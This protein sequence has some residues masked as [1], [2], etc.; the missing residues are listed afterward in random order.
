MMRLRGTFG[1][2]AVAVAVLGACSGTDETVDESGSHVTRDFESSDDGPV[3][4]DSESNPFGGND[5]EDQLMP[6]V[7]C[8][9]LQSAQDEIQDHGVFFSGSTDATGQGRMQIDDSNWIVV[10]QFPAPGIPIGEAD[11]ELYVV[12][13]GEQ[14]ESML[15]H[16]C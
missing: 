12:K 4:T 13:F 16:P 1:A 11:A 7:V 10:D 3:R 15:L 5:A 2:V 8:M 6:D 14:T 9:D